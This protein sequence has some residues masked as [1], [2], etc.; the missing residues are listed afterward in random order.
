MFVL[1]AAAASLAAPSLS[2]SGACPGPVDITIANGTPNGKAAILS[3][4]D[5]GSA[6]FP[7]GPCA[8]DT[9]LSQ[10]GLA[11]RKVVDLDGSGSASLM[12]DLPGGVCG[13]WV[14]VVDV[15]TCE[16][17]PARQLP[18]APDCS[19]VA[20]PANAVGEPAA[21]AGITAGHNE[22]RD[23][24]GVPRVWWNSQLAASAQAWADSC[25]F[26]HDPNR[27][28]DAGYS[29][30]GENIY[31]RSPTAPTAA[32]AVGSWTDERADYDYGTAIDNNNYLIFGH[33]TQAVWDDTESIGCGIA[34]CMSTINWWVV[35]CRYGP[36]GNYIGQTPYDWTSDSCV[37][38]DNDDW[39]QFEDSDDT[40]RNV[41]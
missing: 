27:S 34:D 14:Q 38:L 31:F 29:Y 2:V 35:V 6:P 33:Y 8:G 18:G 3:A 16:T 11:L 4:D 23:R 7:G 40:N 30:V 17:S 22:W 24:V 41:H 9:G 26:G 37:D 10:A 19:F 15:A 20:D 28:P 5:R 32:Q 21:L 13:S 12:P 1:L 39:F 36:G 25:V